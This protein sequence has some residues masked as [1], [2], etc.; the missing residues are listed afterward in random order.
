VLIALI[1]SNTRLI[2][3]HSDKKI[4]EAFTQSKKEKLAL[5][6]YKPQHS[7]YFYSHD[8][9]TILRNKEELSQC[10]N[11]FIVINNVSFE[12]QDKI[13]AIASANNSIIA[14]ANQTR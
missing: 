6:G 4:I 14:I 5:Y 7:T 1:I 13:S 3:K 11:C 10:Q 2:Y 8:H 9:L 12:E